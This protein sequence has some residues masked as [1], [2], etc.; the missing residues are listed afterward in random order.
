[1][2]THADIPDASVPL[3]MS[4]SIV[5]IIALRVGSSLDVLLLLLLFLQSC[6]R[7]SPTLDAYSA[8][9]QPFCS[10]MRLGGAEADVDW[11]LRLEPVIMEMVRTQVCLPNLKFQ[12]DGIRIVT[13]PGADEEKGN[14]AYVLTLTDGECTIQGVSSH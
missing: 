9:P 2:L 5:N 11:E 7:A 4:L 6:S 8:C 13:V 3:E 10:T 14:K 1:M 12:V